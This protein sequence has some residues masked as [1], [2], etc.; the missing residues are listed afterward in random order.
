MRPLSLK[1]RLCVS[2]SLLLAGILVL[3]GFWVASHMREAVTEEITSAMQL[4]RFVLTWRLKAPFPQA[5]LA[6]MLEDFCAL[7]HVRLVLDEAAAPPPPSVPEWFARWVR[8]PALREDYVVPLA[9]AGTLHLILLADPRD[10]IAEA[11]QETKVFLSLIGGLALGVF[12]VSIALIHWAFRPVAAIL[13]GFSALE[14]GEYA[15]RLP[16]FSPP[17]LARIALGFNQLALALEQ[18]KTEN[19]KLTHRL[20]KVQE[21]ERHFLA[22]ELHDELGQTLS[23][24]RVMALSIQN[25]HPPPLVL[26]AAQNI[27]QAAQSLFKS[28]HSMILSLR[29]LMLDDLGLAVAIAQLV[30]SWREKQPAVEI[31]LDCDENIDR[32]PPGKWIHVY[33]IVQEALSNAFKHAQAKRITLTLRWQTADSSLW[34]EVADD[35]QGA[36]LTQ[37]LGCGL[38]LMRERAESLGGRLTLASRPGQGF[39]LS[40]WLPA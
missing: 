38:R 36:D 28:L 26:Q 39:S 25:T 18:A 1:T 8:P 34:L 6:R 17:E 31:E 21:E 10:E 19:L 15:F 40:V 23:A 32:F 22:R 14:R 11:W 30:A 4:A 13:Q 27:A 5:E 2:L 24:I 29:P 7:R 3:S 16:K 37:V 12:G 35:G 33:R 9:P 20:L